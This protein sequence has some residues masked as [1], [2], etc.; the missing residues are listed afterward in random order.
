MKDAARGGHSQMVVLA[1]YSE[2]DSDGARAL[3]GRMEGVHWCS[4][5]YLTH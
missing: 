5:A 3:V 1:S 4:G 2:L